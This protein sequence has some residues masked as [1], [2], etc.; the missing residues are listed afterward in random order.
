MIKECAMYSACKVNICT[1]GKDR[2]IVH[3]NKM[4]KAKCLVIYKVILLLLVCKTYPLLVMHLLGLKSTV[5]TIHQI[6]NLMIQPN[7]TKQ[8]VLPS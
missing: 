1:N 2:C 6:A 5:N 4:G 7:I 3:L 8:A